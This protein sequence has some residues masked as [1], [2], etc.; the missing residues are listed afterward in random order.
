MKDVKRWSADE[1]LSA[2]KT[3]RE[4]KYNKNIYP[5]IGRD[6]E[7]T[8]A[9]VR[10]A[11]ERVK[12]GKSCFQYNPLKQDRRLLSFLD[13]DVKSKEFDFPKEPKIKSTPI[14]TKPI[15]KTGFSLSLCWGLIKITK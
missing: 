15:I 3:A 8:P 7:R 13:T 2:C 1:L 9:S 14:I 10:V 5:L 6:L 12:R 11:V 4:F